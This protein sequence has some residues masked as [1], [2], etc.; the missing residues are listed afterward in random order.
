VT[1]RVHYHPHLI[2]SVGTQVVPLK[3]VIG[4][5]GRTLHPRGAVDLSFH[6]REYE[7]LRTE[8][9]EAFEQSTLPEQPRG[10][11]ALNDLLIRLRLQSQ[12]GA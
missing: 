6:E 12:G 4:Q 5:N 9:E 1:K 11:A 7:R 10:A 2:I 3:D 8:L